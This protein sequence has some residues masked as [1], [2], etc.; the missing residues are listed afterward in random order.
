MATTLLDSRKIKQL[1]PACALWKRYL[2]ARAPFRFHAGNVSDARRWQTRTR[3]ALDRLL[4]FQNAPKVPFS[5]RLI[6]EVDKGDYVRR[7]ILICAFRDSN[8]D[9]P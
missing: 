4:G 1:Q 7:K 8:K 2:P 3:R 9:Q 6:E 5:P